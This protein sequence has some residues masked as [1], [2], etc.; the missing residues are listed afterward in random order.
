MGSIQAVGR[1]A[2]PLLPDR[3]LIQS[4]TILLAGTTAARLLGFLFSVAAAR[5]LAP[6]EY[7]LLAYA[8]AVA[9]ISS[10][11]IGN[12]PTGLSRFLARHAGHPTKQDSYFTNWLVVVAVMLGVSLLAVVPVTVVAGLNARILFG[13]AVNLIGLA[14]LQSYREAQ[15]GLQRFLPMVLF[16]VVANVL[17]L[18][19]ILLAAAL[20]WRTAA[21]FLFIYGLSSVLALAVMQ[22]LA[23]VRLRFSGQTIAWR[24]LWAIGRFLRPILLQTV[25][26]AVWF[27]ADLI[28]VQRIRG[29]ASA[30][31]YAA[32]KTL[33][34]VLLLP[35]MAIG[36]GIAPRVV[37]MSTEALQRYVAGALALTGAALIPGLVMV[38]LWGRQLT[39][40][41]FGSKY[42]DAAKPLAWLA[43]GMV[44]YGL[45]L[46]LECTWMGR[47]RPLIDA[48]AT[49]TGT[50]ST[51][52]LGLFLV[53]RTGLVGAATAFTAGA[54]L[55][56]AVIGW[57]TIHKLRPGTVAQSNR[58]RA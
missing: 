26:F 21:L 5:A 39:T 32:A 42:P 37:R 50:L 8:L 1:V 14:V 15:R 10:I 6:A 13:Q 54:A 46:I 17:Q 36:S 24:R 2:R 44:L 57:Y 41:I 11:L 40:L 51:V 16:S 47:G 25:L 33:L 4:S 58:Q 35:P 28:L 20:G 27:G 3:G 23:P 34:N 29:P 30:G 7:G 38:M 52:T 48:I 12:A 18:V 43:V 19:G 53:P 55:Q 31:N 45:Y 9:T 56:V 22:P 49:G